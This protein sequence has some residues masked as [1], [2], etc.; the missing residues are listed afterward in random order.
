MK[1]Q[2]IGFLDSGVGGLTVVK[3]VMKQLPNEIIYYIGDSARNPYGPRPMEEVQKF[4][5]QLANF[6]FKKEIKLL[7]VACNTA[8]V[9]ALETLKKELPIPVIGVI[10]SGSKAAN[11]STKNHKVGVI[12]TLGT[13]QSNEYE[14]QII[15]KKHGTEV[16]SLACPRFVSIVEKN[17][18]ESTMAKE[19]VHEELHSFKDTDIDT[20]VL[21]CTHYPLLQPIIQDFFG[22]QVNLIDPG[23]ETAKTIKK[24]LTDSNL[25]N[26][27]QGGSTEHLLYT[28]G[29]AENFEK[30]ASNWLNKSN[31]KVK[32]ISVEELSQNE[33]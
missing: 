14:K 23:V 26:Q 8:T 15:N 18:F 25:L 11:E 5:H 24:Y 31:F 28:T 2:P 19:I 21:G 6:L 33:K 29:S 4:T 20:L 3:E 17:Q 9:A 7:V 13:V 27:K 1:K 30:I 32:H 12:G 16:F 22:K 10:E